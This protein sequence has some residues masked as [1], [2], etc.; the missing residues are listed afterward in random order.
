RVIFVER[1]PHAD[2]RHAFEA[3]VERF[4]ARSRDVDAGARIELVVR[5]DIHRREAD[6]A[7]E[8]AAGGDAAVDEAGAAE[9]HRHLRM[10]PL[11]IA[12]R[13]IELDTRMPRT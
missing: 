4:E 12:S 2:V 3:A 9:G 13:T 8:T 6:L 1:R 5:I 11:A 10:A 7:S